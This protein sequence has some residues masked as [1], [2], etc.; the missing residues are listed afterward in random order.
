M[1]QEKAEMDT[2]C[3]L[4]GRDPLGYGLYIFDMGNVVVKNIT[5]MEKIARHYRLP[6]EE[7]LADYQKYEFPLMDGSIDSS[8]YWTHVEK[9]FGVLV[10]GDPLEAFFTPVL[11]PPM[12]NLI[13]RLRSAGKTVVAGTNT[14]APHWEHIKAKGFCTMFDRIYAS[15]EMGITKPCHQ[16]FE[17][18]MK[19]EGQ[20]A[21]QTFFVD[22]YEENV[23]AARALGITVLHYVDD[24]R[25]TA[26]AKLKTVFG[27]SLP[28]LDI[29]DM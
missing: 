29:Q 15:H 14:Y 1:N 6:L 20:T 12:V 2:Y 19:A 7:L 13:D 21:V 10:K 18:I 4:N 11:N 3:N 16:F 23:I 25:M 9:L 22:D 24:D 28:N 26:D 5:T 8:V 17:R 27:T